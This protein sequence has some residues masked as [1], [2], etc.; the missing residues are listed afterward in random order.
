MILFLLVEKLRFDEILILINTILIL[1][2]IICI[3]VFDFQIVTNHAYIF[4]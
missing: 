4:E 3:D 2:K 1:V